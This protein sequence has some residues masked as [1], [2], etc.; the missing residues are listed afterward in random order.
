MKHLERCS[1]TIPK[2]PPENQWGAMAK[3]WANKVRTNTKLCL[4]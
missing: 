2:S 3:A 1:Y 4:G